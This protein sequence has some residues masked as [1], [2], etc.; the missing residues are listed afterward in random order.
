MK[1]YRIK[2]DVRNNQIIY[3]VEQSCWYGWHPFVAR[4]GRDGADCIE[5][6]SEAEAKSALVSKIKEID[7][8]WELK[9]QAGK[10]TYL[11]GDGVVI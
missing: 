9:K 10:P 8:Y 1:E 11:N 6:F 4:Y 5:F 3:T 2:K 7:A